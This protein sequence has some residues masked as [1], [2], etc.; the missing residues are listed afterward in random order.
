MND[1]NP[2]EVVVLC[3]SSRFNFRVPRGCTLLFFLSVMKQNRSPSNRICRTVLEP[4]LTRQSFSENTVVKHLKGALIRNFEFLKINN[5]NPFN[6]VVNE[7]SE[8]GRING[9]VVLRFRFFRFQVF[10]GR[11][12]Y[13]IH[14]RF[15]FSLKI[16][17]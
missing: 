11:V 1:C 9:S 6:T 7:L 12:Q 15:L 3:W 14:G 17:H 16:P 5:G 8:F 2:Q 4:N 13:N 10:W